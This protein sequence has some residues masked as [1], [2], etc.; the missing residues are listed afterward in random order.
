MKVVE[1][2]TINEVTFAQLELVDEIGGIL[3]VKDC[4]A[5]GGI[6]SGRI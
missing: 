6:H 5:P 3:N 2:A 4:A 1:N